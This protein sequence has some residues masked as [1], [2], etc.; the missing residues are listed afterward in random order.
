MHVEDGT[1][2]AEGSLSGTLQVCTASKEGVV[3]RDVA[4]NDGPGGL[5][6]VTVN[7][8]PEAQQILDFVES[9]VSVDMY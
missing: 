4:R 3:L 1:P 2:T 8:A 7:D 6:I 9:L 5:D